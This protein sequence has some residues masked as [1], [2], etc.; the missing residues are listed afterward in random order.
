M[1]YGDL[2]RYH[3]QITDAVSYLHKNVSE[4]IIRSVKDREYKFYFIYVKVIIAFEISEKPKKSFFKIQKIFIG[5][6]SW[7]ECR[8]N[9]F[10]K[11]DTK[12]LVCVEW[13][14]L[15]SYPPICTYEFYILH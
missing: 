4:F 7:L 3:Y 15:W 12:L 6:Y 9:F 5:L 2:L 1:K 14:H 13:N 8:R 11:A 10:G